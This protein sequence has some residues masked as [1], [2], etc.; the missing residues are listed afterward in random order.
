M[1]HSKSDACF[2]L[3]AWHQ[4]DDEGGP[5]IDEERFPHLAEI[6]ERLWQQ[7]QDDQAGSG[8]NDTDA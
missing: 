4:L 7:W 1:P 2:D 5:A 3:R 8:A 6:P